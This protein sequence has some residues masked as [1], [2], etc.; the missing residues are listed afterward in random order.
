MYSRANKLI[1]LWETKKLKI[2]IGIEAQSMEL[3]TT[4]TCQTVQNAV[5]HVGINANYWYAVG[6]A[7]RLKPSNITP[8]VIWQQTIAVS[9][10]HSGQHEQYNNI[11]KNLINRKKIGTRTGTRPSLDLR[12]WSQVKLSYP[13]KMQSDEGNCISSGGSS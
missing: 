8:V 10:N 9:G 11:C 12:L 4:L 6:W 13:K 5:R 1:D 2:K 3:A 7:N